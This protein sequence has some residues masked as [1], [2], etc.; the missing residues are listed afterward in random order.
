[1]THHR[2]ADQP[3]RL[4]DQLRVNPVRRFIWRPVAVILAVAALTAVSL[5]IDALLA[6]GVD[7]AIPLTVARSYLTTIAGT[8]VTATV[9]V[10]W[11]RGLLVTSNAGRFPARI[12][13]GYLRDRYQQTVMGMMIAVFVMA[14]IV[15]LWLPDDPADGAPNPPMP[16]L[17]LFLTA[18]AT[19]VALLVIV[20]SIDTGVRSMHEQRLLRGLLE[21][22]LPIIER[23][24]PEHCPSDEPPAGLPDGGSVVRAAT[25]GWVASVDDDAILGSLPPGS[26][27]RRCVRVGDFVTPATRLC[28]I[29]TPDGT[30]GPDL[31]GDEVRAAFEIGE[32]RS[33]ENDIGFALRSMVDVALSGL[34]DGS[35]DRTTAREAIPH[36]GAVLRLLV[37]RDGPPMASSDDEGRWMVLEGEPD[38]ERYLDE[39]FEDLR[40]EGRDPLTAR[41]LLGTIEEL[42]DAAVEAGR[43]ERAAVLR[44]QVEL[45]V[46]QAGHELSLDAE[47]R[48]V[49]ERA[50]EI[51]GADE[52]LDRGS[53]SATLGARR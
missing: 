17:S 9:V 5:W 13:S 43:P 16:A 7:R 32:T 42:V 25:I 39:A 20:Q 50:T 49:Q 41:V 22:A 11:I 33:H 19:V 53:H 18:L 48:W 31:P 46:A 14:S 8:M 27:C 28:R 1:M 51:D 37:I 47:R 24:Y 21:E 10:F 6:T 29:T 12:L 34:A 52:L 35:T 30:E 45:I 38:Y 26:V 15:L 23:D 36:I 44:R 3:R 40:R 2:P 4:V